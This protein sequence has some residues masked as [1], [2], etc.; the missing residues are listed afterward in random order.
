MIKLLGY[1]YNIVYRPGKDNK[2][3]DALS[4]K[5]GSSIIWFIYDE[6]EPTL[7]AISGAK[8]H[9]WDKIREAVLLDQRS[10]EIVE[11]LKKNEDGVSD[12]R[13]RDELIYYRN[14]VYVPDILGLR[15]EKL[16]YF[17]KGKKERHSSWLRTYV[18]MK[19]F[20]F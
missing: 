11:K 3:V 5:E 1:E 8:W 10:Q 7:C 20:F 12:Y 17:Y 18:W 14:H 19:Q 16:R 15:D 9:I 13:V 6:D 2:V 4:R